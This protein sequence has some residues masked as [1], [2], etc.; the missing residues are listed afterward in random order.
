MQSRLALRI[1]LPALAGIFLAAAALAD[2]PVDEAHF[3][4]GV[5]RAYVLEQFDTDGSGALDGDEIAGA[6]A[7]DCF[8]LGVSSLAGIEYLTEQE[9]LDCQNNSLTALD[10]SANPALTWLNCGGNQLTALDLSANPA[11]TWLNCDGNQ[12]TALDLSANPALTE[13]LCYNNQLTALDLSANSALTALDCFKNQ[14]TALNLSANPELTKLD[15]DG[16]QL[17][18]LDLSANPSL[19][20]L[21]CG[22]NQLTA[23]NLSA[24][25]ALTSLSCDGNQLTALNLSA[26]PALT[27]LYCYENSRTISVV[28][29][30]FQLSGLPLFDPA[31]AS[32]WQGGAVQD[33]VLTV[34]AGA[35]AVTYTY[36]CG[37]GFTA[38]FRLVPDEISGGYPPPPVYLPASLKRIESGAFAGAKIAALLLPDGI[39]AIAGDAFDPNVVLYYRPGTGAEAYCREHA[40]TLPRCLPYEE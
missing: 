6:K 20:E 33:G 24:N 8:G 17:T 11:L 3:P 25:P 40:E 4:D 35:E 26:N 7:I 12:L 15:C 38:D 13:L 5:F 27:T 30:Q 34:D 9:T 37:N 14:L 2:V 39:T 28:N 1:L 16:N 19:T 32:G 36:D 22:G 31:R 23:L 29:G 18:A 21:N 10:L